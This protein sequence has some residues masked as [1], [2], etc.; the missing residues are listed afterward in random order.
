MFL[1]IFS[2][3]KKDKVIEHS[4]IGEVSC[5]GFYSAFKKC[6]EISDTNL[7]D[8][9]CRSLYDISY[10]CYRTKNEEEFSRWVDSEI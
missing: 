10:H 8:S 1:N 7:H 2:Y 5:G 4:V 9:K 3:V 6:L